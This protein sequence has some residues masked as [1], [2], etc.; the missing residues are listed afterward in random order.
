MAIPMMIGILALMG[1]NLID[2][3]F[4]AQIGT[5]ELAAISFTFPV[6]NFIGSVSLSFGIALSSIVSRLIGAQKIGR[7]KCVISQAILS[8]FLFAA[9]LSLLGILCIRPL[10]KLLGATPEIMPLIEEYMTIWF[11]Y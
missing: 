8:S 9:C 1:F 5:N 6:V 4:I 2:T 3:F 7:L 11:L 10:F